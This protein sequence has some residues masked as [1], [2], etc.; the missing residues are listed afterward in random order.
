[1]AGS[2][3]FGNPRGPG[4]R[5]VDGPRVEGVPRK[6]RN[7]ELWQPVMLN[8]RL[9]ELCKERGWNRLTMTSNQRSELL[10]IIDT[11]AVPVHSPPEPIR[12]EP[13]REFLS[14]KSGGTGGGELP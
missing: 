9:H 14:K 11:E 2:S 3:M 5:V 6:P 10:A 7:Y 4:N 12:R 8:T 1:M 13:P